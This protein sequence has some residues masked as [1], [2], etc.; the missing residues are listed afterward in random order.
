MADPFNINSTSY[1][2][3]IERVY[4]EIARSII[5]KP[6][7][8]LISLNNDGKIDRNK[9]VNIGFGIISISCIYSYAAIEAFCNR[10]L[11][12]FQDTVKKIESSGAGKAG[13]RYMGHSSESLG[14]NKLDFN[15]KEDLKEKIKK[16]CVLYK[17]KTIC[18][19]NPELWGKFNQLLKDARHF[20]IHPKPEP[21]EFQE[22]INKILSNHNTGEYVNIASEILE[23]YYTGTQKNPPEWLKKNSLLD[24]SGIN[25][26]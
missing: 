24:F 2:F 25:V 15:A 26:V 10:H 14:E 3:Q 5:D 21:D 8:E 1:Q 12:G 11:W 19:S 6:L 22:N 23:Y 7:K 17:I 13:W 20:I 16:L 18:D 9:V 4:L